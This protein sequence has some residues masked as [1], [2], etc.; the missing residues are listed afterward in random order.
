MN[1]TRVTLIVAAIAV[2]SFAVMTTFKKK[3]SNLEEIVVLAMNVVGAVT[4]VYIFVGAF[5]G[6]EDL[7]QNSTWAG[8]TGICMVIYFFGKI[9]MAFLRLFSE[10]ARPQNP[11]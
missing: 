5:R 3:E 6:I 8:I 1:E 10:E 2:V 4:G 11:T 7:T 9:R